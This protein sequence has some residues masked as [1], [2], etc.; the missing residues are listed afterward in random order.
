MGEGGKALLGWKDIVMFSHLGWQ[1]V[2]AILT[3]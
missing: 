2:K 1:R 3:D